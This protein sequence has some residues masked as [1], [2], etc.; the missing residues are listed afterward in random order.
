MESKMLLWPDKIC[1]RLSIP[2]LFS[3]SAAVCWGAPPDEIFRTGASICCVDASDKRACGDVM[4]PQ[5]S[6]RALKIYNRQGLLVREVAARMTPEEKARA[7]EQARLEK[8][9]QD[10]IRKQ[11]REDQALLLGYTSLE[12]FDR[13]Q[14]R[15]ED[16]LKA[17]I[18]SINAQIIAAKQ[19][20]KALDAEAEFYANHPN[21]LPPDLSLR[22]H[23]EEAEIKTQNELLAAKQKELAQM[24]KKSAEERRR[25]I[26]LS[27]EKAAN[28]QE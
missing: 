15:K 6:G 1:R 9:I 22:Q 5:C 27:S 18:T 7:A 14:K 4:P 3:M 28:P 2:V 16:E 12:D 20:R 8:Q 13:V 26:K 21:G 23:N 25:Y 10:A 11:R 19:R 24:R 17:L